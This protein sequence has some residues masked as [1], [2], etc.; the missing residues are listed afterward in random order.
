MKGSFYM[1]DTLRILGLLVGFLYG[2]TTYAQELHFSVPF[3]TSLQL[4]PALT[5]AIPGD[6]RIMSAYKNQWASIGTPFQTIY[7]SFD[8]KLLNTD[9]DNNHLGAGISF[10]SDKAG[11]TS[12]GLTQ[13]NLHFAYVFKI[14][15]TQFVSGGIQT[16]F[17]Q[18]STNYE[19]IKWDNQYNGVGYDPSL[20]SGETNLPQNRSYFDAGAG[21]TW[22]YVPN[23]KFKTKVGW[24]TYHLTMPNVSNF[25]EGTDRLKLR[26]TLHGEAELMLNKQFTLLPQ[27]VS[28]HK[29]PSFE[30]IAG[31]CVKYVTGERSKYT[32]ATIPST[33]SL[34][35]YYRYDDAVIASVLYEYRQMLSIG[36][37]YDLNISPLKVATSRRGGVEVSLL[38]NGVFEKQVIKL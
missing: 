10:F 26:M 13:L 12:M 19:G 3:R 22:E 21:V 35:A 23:K 5:A 6:F 20:P 25:D 9:E 33:L 17:V 31:V 4:N 24:A 34:G 1:G 38:F 16:G 8:M 15:N 7:G 32:D 18:R 29:G 30:I 14:G 37:S 27:F 2:W 11:K 28:M 36:V